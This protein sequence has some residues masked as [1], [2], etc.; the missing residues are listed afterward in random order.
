MHLFEWTNK[1]FAIIIN[2][3][4]KKEMGKKLYIPVCQNGRNYKLYMDDLAKARPIAK[5]TRPPVPSY[6]ENDS[7]VK[8]EAMTDV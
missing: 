8:Y 1:S 5:K 2:F 7:L 4:R 6:S 3:E